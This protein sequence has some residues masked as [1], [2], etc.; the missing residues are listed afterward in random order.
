MIPPRAGMMAGMM[1]G[2]PG[3]DTTEIEKQYQKH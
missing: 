3:I 1:A 2:G